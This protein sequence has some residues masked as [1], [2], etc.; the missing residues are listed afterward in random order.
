MDILFVLMCS[1]RC[2]SHDRD[3]VWQSVC[4]SRVWGIEIHIFINRMVGRLAF[5]SVSNL[6]GLAFQFISTC[7]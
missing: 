7:L 6:A 2:M 4:F 1:F 3:S 5:S